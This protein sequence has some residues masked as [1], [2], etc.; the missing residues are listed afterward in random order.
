MVVAVNVKVRDVKSL[1]V[2]FGMMGLLFSGCV[3]IFESFTVKK[4]RLFR[5]YTGKS[6]V[7]REVDEKGWILERKENFDFRM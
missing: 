4:S 5:I 1:R 7:L 3:I 2:L 6:V